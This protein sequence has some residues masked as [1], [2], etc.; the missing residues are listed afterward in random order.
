MDRLTKRR[1][2]GKVNAC[3][4]NTIIHYMHI[5]LAQLATLLCL[6]RGFNIEYNQYVLPEISLYVLNSEQRISYCGNSGL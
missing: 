1:C 3:W 6:L 4:S 5:D 2:I